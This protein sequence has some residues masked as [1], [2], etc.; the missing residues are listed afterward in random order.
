MEGLVCFQVDMF[1]LW[2]CPAYHLF[3]PGYL[4]FRRESI[5]ELGLCVKYV[6]DVLTRSTEFAAVRSRRLLSDS[7][8]APA[9]DFL[10][11][12]KKDRQLFPA[13]GIY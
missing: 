13:T 5:G 10:L 6:E 7:L 2:Y 4:S 8:I 9:S 12:R 1:D 3:Q 11:R